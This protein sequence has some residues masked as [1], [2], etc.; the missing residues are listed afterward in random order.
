MYKT[1][2]ILPI[3]SVYPI[4]K[5]YKPKKINLILD[6]DETLLHTV[7]KEKYYDNNNSNTI[8]KSFESEN[9]MI[10]PRPFL[11]S[12]LFVTSKFANLHLMTKST[13]KHATIILETLKIQDY[14][15]E[16]KYREDLTGKCKDLC[17]ILHSSE[18]T[19]SILVDDKKSNQCETQ[20]LYHI[21]KFNVYTKYDYELVKLFLY[22]LFK[23]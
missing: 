21:P 19:N 3:L 2:P 6:M 12:F 1:I 7:R 23:Y 11:F 17:I 8:T 18:L 20:N 22:L 9:H 15:I 10:F 14:F 13:K 16:K 4:Y 5:F